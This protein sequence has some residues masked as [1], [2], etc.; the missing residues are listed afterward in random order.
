MVAKGTRRSL[1]NGDKNHFKP[2]KKGL[3][4]DLFKP[5]G[6]FKKKGTEIFVGNLPPNI[7]EEE[8]VLLFKDFG[9]KAVRKKQTSAFKSFAFLD[10]ASPEVVQLAVQTMNGNV[11]NG[12]RIVVSVS[13]E[14]RSPEFKKNHM[15]MP[16]LEPVPNG[17]PVGNGAGE[18][19]SKEDKT[20]LIPK[21][22]IQTAPPLKK[23]NLYAIPIEMRSSFLVLMLKDCFKDLGWLITI[24]RISGEA[25]LLVTD[26]VPQTPFFW[27]IHL[28]EENHQ[29]MH[30][31]F[32]SLAEVESQ[33]PFLAK[34][35]IQRGTRCMAECI[36]GEEGGAWNRCWVLDK[37]GNMVVVFFMDFGRSATVP[38]NSLRRLDK[39]DFWTI[40]PLAQPFMLHEDVLPPQLM[41]RQILEGRVIAQSHVET[42][43]LRFITKTN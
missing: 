42:H 14:R 12:Q 10:V 33:L 28:T 20:D 39:D 8:I 5:P 2:G 37:V 18:R 6:F 4:S 24:C 1:H 32:S 23:N 19:S 25:G 3:K 9:L 35:D 7:T 13:E 38:L 15:E 16:D 34:Q 21:T 43:I 36:L 40:P 27:A 22:G 41:V 31:L 26:T 29:N 11:V 17:L 30:K